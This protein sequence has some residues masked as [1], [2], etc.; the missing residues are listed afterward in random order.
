MTVMLFK[1]FSTVQMMII[2]L[3]F[4]PSSLFPHFGCVS[5]NVVL[6]TLEYSATGRNCNLLTNE[7]DQKAGL[8]D[9]SQWRG[10]FVIRFL[11][12]VSCIRV[13]TLW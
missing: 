9:G 7:Q 12:S 11:L 3:K 5:S 10:T 6:A 13:S 1:Y 8:T 2:V 4:C